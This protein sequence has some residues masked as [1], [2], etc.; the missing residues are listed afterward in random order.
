V[1][2]RQRD[3]LRTPIDKKRVG[4]NEQRAAGLL[5]EVCEGRIDLATGTG[6]KDFDWMS[7]R[8]STRLQVFDLGLGIRSIGVDERD[9]AVAS[10]RY[11]TQHPEPLC[12]KLHKLEVY[13]GGVAARPVE[14]ADET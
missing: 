5:H 1:A 10:G 9:E 7:K 6:A 8:R 4:T 12:H 14:A 13:A 2:R 3:D 11:L